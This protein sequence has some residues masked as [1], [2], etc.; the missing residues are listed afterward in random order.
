MKQLTRIRL[1]NWHLFHDTTVTCHGSTYFIGVNGVGKSTILDAIQ[2]A[3]V[4]GQR[5][6]KF[7]QA[8]MAGSRRTLTSYVR[9]EL[10]TEGQRFLRGDA[11]GLVALEFR[12]PDGTYFVHGAII[13]AYE[14]GR[15]PDV[16]YFIVHEAALNDDWFF[17]APGLLYDSRSFRR[18][19]EHVTLPGP[20]A[21][22]QV[23]TRLEDYRF[24]LLNRLGQLKETF[25][26]KIIKGLA[27]SPLI[28]IRDFVH[29]YLLDESLVEVKN[30]Q[31]QLETMRHFESLAA[32]IIRRIERL[33]E[34]EELDTERR[35]QRRLR[36]TN[37]F[38]ARQAES[39]ATLT[40]LKRR[41]VEL[42]EGQIDLRRRELHRDT[43]TEQL[44]H[45]NNALIEAQ[46]AYRTD[47]TAAQE[48]ALREKI[49]QLEH[50]LADLRRRETALNQTLTQEI[51]DARRL[52]SYLDTDNLPVPPA[53]QSFIDTTVDDT[54]HVSRT[55]DH[56]TQLQVDLQQ[57]G[58]D[59]ATQ[60][61]LLKNQSDQLR[62]EAEQLQREINQLRTGDRA[63][64]YEAE[65]PQSNR[66]RRLL[67]AE[68]NLSADEVIPLYEALRVP[69]EAWQNAVEGILG[70]TRFD[71]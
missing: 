11:T 45:A 68:L 1:V 71:L 48:K 13:D 49:A 23:F 5:D 44:K 29:S 52:Q 19:L 12:N 25:T 6:V 16:S 62:R 39:D 64:S 65:A 28:N 55:I 22:A 15:S 9:G 46:V 66:L 35:T 3:L 67:R 26:A 63:A 27:F 56:V 31:E 24:H 50:N 41:R 54:S 32:D 18:H 37:G 42:D 38:I 30:L 8:A 4:G 57:L 53:L 47:A 7:N 69:D 2:F 70:R 10:G 21:R 61:A 14:D 36:L 58:N 33:N 34:I 51:A 20:Q 59:Y 40:E 17:R 43:L 60:H